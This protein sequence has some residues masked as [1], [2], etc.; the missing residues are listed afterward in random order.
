[1]AYMLL[2][3][4]NIL[5]VA[6]QNWG[7]VDN[8]RYNCCFLCADS[9]LPVLDRYVDQRVDCMIEA[10]LLNEVFDIYRPNAD[11]TRGLRQ[12]I[13]VREFEI[14][15]R[16]CTFED[17]GDAESDSTDRSLFLKSIN[18]GN[19]MSM[20]NIGVIL[21]FFNDKQPKMLLK[22]AIEKMKLNTRRLVRRQVSIVYNCLMNFLYMYSYEITVFFFFLIDLQLL[23]FPIDSQF[24]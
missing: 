23:N 9:S 22:E 7:R 14:F 11:Y 17:K 15:L 21:D 20:E 2:N 13:G 4:V 19:I 5:H 24:L 16:V 10:G 6:G 3:Y 1:M 18:E 8:F 12:A